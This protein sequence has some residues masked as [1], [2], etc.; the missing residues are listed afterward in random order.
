MFDDVKEPEDIF[1]GTDPVAPPKA[2]G[3]GAEKRS[4]ADSVIKTGPSPLIYIVV[5]AIVFGAFGGGG[6]YW[7]LMQSGE[8]PMID[9]TPAVVD[10]NGDTTSNGQTIPEPIPGEPE[11][12]DPGV[13]DPDEPGPESDATDPVN[14]PEPDTFMDTDGDGLT[15]EEE[16][17]LGTDP[18]SADTDND[19]LTDFDEV[20]IYQTDPTMPDT[21]GDGFLDG[22]EVAGGYNPN[23]PGK[24]FEIPK[25]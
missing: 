25:Q 3:E 11:P 14:D 20:R 10:Q 6:Y 21:D 7:W 1:A 2:P 15:D 19:G 9:D 12:I 17:D 22:Q 23:G 18:K 13:A 8:V 16:M 5:G 24:L 4:V